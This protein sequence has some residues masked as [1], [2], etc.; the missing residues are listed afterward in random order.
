MGTC[1]YLGY[2]IHTEPHEAIP[3]WTV[4]TY[5]TLPTDTGLAVQPLHIP[6]LFVSRKETEDE[7]VQCA[8]AWIGRQT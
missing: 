7:G 6:G 2:E 1:A 5:L 4:Y 3:G 8:K